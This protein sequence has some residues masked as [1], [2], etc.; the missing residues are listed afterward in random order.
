MR[1]KSD[2]R[3]LKTLPQTFSNAL[4]SPGVGTGD[5]EVNQTWLLSSYC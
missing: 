3:F 2:N 1:I 4:F 5:A